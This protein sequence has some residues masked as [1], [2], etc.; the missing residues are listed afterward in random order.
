MR[1][2]IDI[3]GSNE[4]STL[5]HVKN[6]ESSSSTLR[7]NITTARACKGRF[8]LESGVQ[9]GIVPHCDSRGK[10]F[11]QD[12]RVGGRYRFIIIIITE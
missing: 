12:I 6:T 5:I 2:F 7:H 4:Y 1:N 10:L 9:S 8:V 3:S 11:L